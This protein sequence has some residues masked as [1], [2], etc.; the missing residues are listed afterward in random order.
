MIFFHSGH[1]KS[2]NFAKK[3]CDVL[4]LLLNSDSSIKKLKGN[5]RPI[6]SLN[7]R[8]KLLEDLNIFNFILIFDD[9]HINNILEKVY[10]NIFFKGGDY[11]LN[12]LEKKFPNIKII[13]SEHEDNIS[14]TKI[15]EKIN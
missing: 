9:I 13:L 14:T 5:N 7:H 12:D 10:F 1:L 2:I 8:K 4:I 3:N 6:L 11:N 15:I